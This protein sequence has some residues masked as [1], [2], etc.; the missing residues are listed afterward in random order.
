MDSEDFGLVEHIIRIVPTDAHIPLPPLD[1]DYK[2]VGDFTMRRPAQ[3]PL[4]LK[5]EDVIANLKI[6]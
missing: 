6:L 2:W 4:G 1:V 3:C 5:N